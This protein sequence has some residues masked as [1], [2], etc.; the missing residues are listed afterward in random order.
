MIA[1]LTLALVLAFAGN[2]LAWLDNKPASYTRVL[3][4]YA[5]STPVPTAA[6]DQPFP[7][8]SGWNI[9]YPSGK[10]TSV[11][12]EDATCDT[13]PPYSIETTYNAGDS[14]GVGNATIYKYLPSDVTE[15]YVAL[16]VWWDPNYEWNS[17]SN[18]LFYLEPGNIILQSKHLDS[19][20]NIQRYLTVYVGGTGKDYMPT[21]PQTITLGTC[22]TI[23]Y[24]VKR[25]ASGHLK[26]WLDGVQVMDRVG[27]NIPSGTSGQWVQ[28]DDTWGGSTGPRTRTSKRRVGHIYL[29]TV[30]AGPAPEPTPIPTPTPTPTPV[31]TPT[32]AER[33][34][35][36]E[37]WKAAVCAA[38]KSMGGTTSF[39][40]KVKATCP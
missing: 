11:R 7:D 25:G 18:K 15:L 26:V 28:I 1:R 40:A 13:S 3:S 35:A 22:H 2:A 10:K 24:L 31:P 21:N 32:V 12:V 33:V 5:F 39:A 9:I 38:A 8:G 23:E 27:I 36:L 14:S 16:Q 4:D 19:V 29:A 37:S 17:I 34:T 30:G 20:T 6:T